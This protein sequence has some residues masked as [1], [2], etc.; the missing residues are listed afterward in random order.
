MQ[1][2]HLP[3]PVGHGQL[4]HA[5]LL[6]YGMAG[7]DHGLAAHS[8]LHRGDALHGPGADGIRQG[9]VHGLGVAGALLRD[10]EAVLGLLHVAALQQLADAVGIVEVADAAVHLAKLQQRLRIHRGG[11]PPQHEEDQDLDIQFVVNEAQLVHGKSSVN[12]FLS[13][14]L[15]CIPTI[16]QG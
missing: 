15:Y 10:L 16:F 7:G 3:F 4:H 13:C 1:M 14:T 11:K 8:L 9:V 5:A 12:S 2:D 6:I